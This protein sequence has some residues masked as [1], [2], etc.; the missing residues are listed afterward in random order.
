MGCL[1]TSRQRSSRDHGP[2]SRL[3]VGASR[4]R[5]SVGRPIGKAGRPRHSSSGEDLGMKIGRWALLVLSFAVDA[6]SIEDEGLSGRYVL[7]QRTVVLAHIPILP[8]L[9]TETWSVSLVDLASGPARL[10]GR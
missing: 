6:R 4:G 9:S 2:L 10:H 7:S 3:R 1:S 5:R 8:D